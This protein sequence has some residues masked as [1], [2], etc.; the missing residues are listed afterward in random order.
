MLSWKAV[1]NL[2]REIKGKGREQGFLF[3]VA[4]RAQ[5]FWRYHKKA[6]QERGLKKTEIETNVRPVG[7]RKARGRA[8]GKSKVSKQN[9]QRTIPGILAR[10][11]QQGQN[12]QGAH[13]QRHRER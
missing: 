9:R 12:M 1:K 5:D 2:G 6:G 8:Q 3:V 7:M 11:W 10:A 4:P 13:G